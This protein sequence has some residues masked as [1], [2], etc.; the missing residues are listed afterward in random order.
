MRRSVTISLCLVAVIA[1]GAAAW[2]V[3]IRPALL[4]ERIDPG[5][6]SWWEAPAAGA[7]VVTV[8]QVEPGQCLSIESV[9]LFDVVPDNLAE[10]VVDCESASSLVRV[11]EVSPDEDP[12]ESCPQSCLDYVDVHGWHYA[13]NVIP[14]EGL[15][16]WGYSHD[17]AGEPL[18]LRAYTSQLGDCQRPFPEWL[19]PD[20]AADA[21]STDESRPVEAADLTDYRYRILSVRA[22][23]Q[24]CDERDGSNQITWTTHFQEDALTK[25]CTSYQPAD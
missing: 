10:A 7:T 22:P 11:I 17:V 5:A 14:R 21:F 2:L 1:V 25:L 12:S 20:E 6:D 8:A 24:A 9:L 19:S 3:W 23:D 18:H 13:V 16:M 15:C 4:M